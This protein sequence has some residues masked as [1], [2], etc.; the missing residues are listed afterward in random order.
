VY[1]GW[2]LEEEV[3]SEVKGS[4]RQGSL[5]LA[6]ALDILFSQNEIPE[7]IPVSGGLLFQYSLIVKERGGAVTLGYLH[8]GK[9]S[10]NI[11]QSSDMNVTF[12]S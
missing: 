12:S 7:G 6:Q 3:L 9:S 8:P 11:L 5:Q 1:P 4:R 2:L 10:Y